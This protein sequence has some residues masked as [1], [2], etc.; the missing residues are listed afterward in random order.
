MFRSIGFPQPF[1]YGQGFASVLQVCRGIIQVIEKKARYLWTTMG[2]Q[3]NHLIC[4]SPMVAIT[5]HS[6]LLYSILP[7][8]SGKKGAIFLF[9][10]TKVRVSLSIHVLRS[11]FYRNQQ[12]LNSWG[13]WR[14]IPWP[15]IPFINSQMEQFH[16]APLNSKL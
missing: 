10:L 15:S 6:L 4:A 16:N 14:W 7:E 9:I 3:P 11:A 1:Y 12:F 8:I 5:Q 2:N 13:P